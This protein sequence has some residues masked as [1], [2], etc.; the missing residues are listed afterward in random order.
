MVVLGWGVVVRL[1]S[2]VVRRPVAGLVRQ[3]TV[4]LADD[5][6]DA[7][8]LVV[9]LALGTPWR[10]RTEFRGEEVLD[11]EAKGALPMDLLGLDGTLKDARA[12]VQ[13]LAVSRDLG[14]SQFRTG[15]GLL[16]APGIRQRD[17]LAW[18]AH[19]RDVHQRL[20]QQQ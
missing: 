9:D 1:G 2:S 17:K 7:C 20:A 8:K 6:A 15:L 4:Q 18:W 12:Q 3:M 10:L 16:G 19:R 5:L 14:M 13:Q 11:G